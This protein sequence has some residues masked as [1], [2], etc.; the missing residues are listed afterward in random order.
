MYLAV[1]DLYKGIF[2]VIGSVLLDI[3]IDEAVLVW[4]DRHASN[5]DS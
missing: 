3:G 2:L 4:E 5:T 1:E